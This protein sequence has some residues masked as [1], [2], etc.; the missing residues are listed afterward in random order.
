[1]LPTR[2]TN[3]PTGSSAAGDDTEA[4]G[5]RVTLPRTGVNTLGAA[6]ISLLL[7]LTGVALLRVSAVRKRRA[8]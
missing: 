4:S 6:A 2:F 1:V 3:S 7:L 8:H 5:T